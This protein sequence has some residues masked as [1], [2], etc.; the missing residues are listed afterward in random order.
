MDVIGVVGEFNPFHLGHQ[1][2]FQKSR[3]Q[4]GEDAPIVCVMS[5]DFVQRGGP[6]CF[7]KH[8]RA[9]MA[10]RCGA[11]LVFELPLPWCASSAERFAM[12]AVG[13]LDS[14]GVVTHLSFGSE[15]GS[16]APLTALALAA[17]EPETVEAVK[18]Q[19]EQGM[20]FAAAREKVLHETL[21]EEARL[22]QTPNNILAVEYLKALFALYSGMTPM[23]TLRRESR[24]DA[25]TGGR[26][27]SAGQLRT[28]QEAGEDIDAFIPAAAAK[29]AARERAAGRGPVTV[30]GMEAVV[31]SRLRMLSQE[32]FC[33]LPDA[34]EGLGN[35][36]YKAVRDQGSLMG[37][38]AAVKTKRYPLSRLRRMAFAAALG[39][40]AGVGDTVPPYAR[41]LASTER[42]RGL[43]RAM[44][45]EGKLPIVNK[46]AG[47]KTL[48]EPA[49]EIF[50]LT[51]NARDFYVLGYS[52]AAERA[53]GSDWRTS[54]VTA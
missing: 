13:L 50:A 43:L 54:P 6:A 11:D 12:G 37:V 32:D 46:P 29:L 40:R 8:V 20:P 26:I 31:M 22:L 47:I 24:H 35:R 48:R 51:A 3:E 7:N 21:G 33:A 5:G 28:M 27:R 25:M 16:L 38:L 53:G 17:L 44:V 4:L 39:I 19:M 52:A 36:L 15:A 41:L 18:E 10:L 2:H 14:L 45:R 34:T 1:A 49:A 23:T 9:E 42:G 30:E